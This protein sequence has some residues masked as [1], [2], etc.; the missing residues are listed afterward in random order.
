MPSPLSFL[1]QT[2]SLSSLLSFLVNSTSICY[3]PVFY[4]LYIPS[5]STWHRR[6]LFSSQ[7]RTL[8]TSSFITWMKREIYLNSISRAMAW[9]LAWSTLSTSA[10]ICWEH[11]PFYIF[12]YG[13]P[14][15]TLKHH[16]RLGS[17]KVQLPRV[18]S[19]RVRSALPRT[20]SPLF[21]LGFLLSL[22]TT[23]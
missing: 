13:R 7:H 20:F 14:Q 15:I 16:R 4:F 5:R 19:P 17:F 22:L 1:L 9:L 6:V 23:V 11:Q 2:C 8:L 18:Q 12:S 21:V 10:E 3:N